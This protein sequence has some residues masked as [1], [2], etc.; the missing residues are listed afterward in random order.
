MKI[1]V[2]IRRGNVHNVMETKHT[3][4]RLESSLMHHCEAACLLD[5]LHLFLDVADLESG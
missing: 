3:R 2:M 4:L 1:M 5:R